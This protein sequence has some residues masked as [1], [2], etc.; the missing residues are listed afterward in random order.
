M[1]FI[2]LFLHFLIQSI[3]L[4]AKKPKKDR[5]IRKTKLA[6]EDEGLHPS[7]KE[8]EGKKEKAEKEVKLEGK[9]EKEAKNLVKVDKPKEKEKEKEGIMKG[10]KG[11]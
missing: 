8:K 3:L 4:E 6:T 1:I 7:D 10:T 2:Y 11:L 9:K 5:K